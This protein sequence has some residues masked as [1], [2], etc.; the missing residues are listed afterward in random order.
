MK[1]KWYVSCCLVAAILPFTAVHSHA[2]AI[3]PVA[4]VSF[5]YYDGYTPITATFVGH[6]GISSSVMDSDGFANYQ[7]S[8]LMA[9]VANKNTG[10]E[11][12]STIDDLL[13]FRVPSGSAD[14]HVRIDGDFKF[15]Y[16]QSTAVPSVELMF[17]WNRMDIPSGTVLYQ[18]GCAP[19]G[20]TWGDAAFT[21]A[22]GQYLEGSYSFNLP[23]TVVDGAVYRLG[24]G[25]K[26][27][28][29]AGNSAYI[30]DPI[31]IDRPE[32]VTFVA[33]GGGTYSGATVPLP[34]AILLLG[35]GFVALSVVRRTI[36]RRP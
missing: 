18:T 22:G 34:G 36:R 24:A 16:V 15:S 3:E 4:T 30:I 13:T 6:P 1:A 31:I 14:I 9:N 10:V 23:L 7:T 28:G 32:G 20:V 5:L 29:L 33:S 8:A 11:V 21:Y 27:I 26:A 25:L 12:N 2:D 35:P 19:T 17:V